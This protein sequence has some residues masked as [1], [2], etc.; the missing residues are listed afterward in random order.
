MTDTT[1]QHFI[2]ITN[3]VVNVALAFVAISGNALVLYGVWKTPALRSPS[4]LLICGLA[5]TD[6]CVGLIAQPLVIVTSFIN[7][8]SHSVNLK[9]ILNQAT[10]IIAL[11]LCGVSLFMITGI[12][13]DR[14]IAIVK[15]LQYPSIVTSSRVTRILVV[16][17]TVCTLGPSTLFW[18]VRLLFALISTIIFLCLCISIICHATI[19]KIMRRHRLQI[20]SQIQAFEDTNARTNMASLRKSAFNAFVVFIVLVICY[21]P[22][23]VV[24]I[25]S[26]KTG[27]VELLVLLSGTVVFLNSALNPLLYC[28]RISEI[29]LALL[30]TIRRLVSG[31]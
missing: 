3:C 16:I 6:L 1:A 31:E 11:S 20:H 30:Q 4:I 10:F 14:L 12:S 29:R 9:S 26:D 2:I 25:F 5:S 8:Y 15:P 18:D 24:C 19:Y 13:I 28:W 7:L 21:F 17:W 23:L 22:F 27:D